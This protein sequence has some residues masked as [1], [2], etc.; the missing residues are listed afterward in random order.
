MMGSS[1][2]KPSLTSRISA[3]NPNRRGAAF[4]SVSLLWMGETLC[5]R[6]FEYL[7]FL[8]ELEANGHE[9]SKRRPAWATRKGKTPE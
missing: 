6:G 4:P 5:P 3:I 2:R 1:R 8:M 9:T 7:C